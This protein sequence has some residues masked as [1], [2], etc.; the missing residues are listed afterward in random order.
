MR[1][2]RY[3]VS[4]WVLTIVLLIGPVIA[5]ALAFDASSAAQRSPDV[6]FVLAEKVDC[7]PVYPGGPAYWTLGQLAPS[8]VIVGTVLVGVC[9]AAR[10]IIVTSTAQAT[11][12]R[13]QAETGEQTALP[14]ARLDHDLFRRPGSGR[15]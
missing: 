8:L 15:D 14:A 12:E 9:L 5:V 1:P 4:L 6:C 2:G 3:E 13:K 11:D 10:A 7:P